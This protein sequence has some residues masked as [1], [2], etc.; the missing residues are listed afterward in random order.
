MWTKRT[1]AWLAVLIVALVACT[2]PPP[3]PTA[4]FDFLL[5]DTVLATVPGTSLTTSATITPINGFTGIVDLTIANQDGSP[6]D[7][8]ITLDPSTITIASSDLTQESIQRQVTID[9]GLA[10]VNDTYPLRITAANGSLN[11]NADLTLTVADNLTPLLTIT[12]HTDGETITGSRTVTLFG[13]L[14]SLNPIVAVDVLGGADLIFMSFDQSTFKAAIELEN[15]A[16]SVYVSGTDDQGRVGVSAEIA[17]SFP[18]LDLADFQNAS[19]VVG[20]PDFISN[21]VNQGGAAASNTLQGALFGNPFVTDSGMLFLPDSQN[22]RMLGFNL[23]PD[24]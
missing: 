2:T 17:L 20:Q 10:V 6:A 3:A 14:S 4:D 19:L 9:V 23:V 1:A 8:G 5:E 12:S 21:D 11:S 15:N 16:N 13:T 7:P 18:F 22:H 24:S